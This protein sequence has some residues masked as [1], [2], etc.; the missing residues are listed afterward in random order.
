MQE[1]ALT[2]EKNLLF[3]S[4]KITL[5]W[6]WRSS[7]GEFTAPAD[8]V[9]RHLF[10]TFRMIWNNAMPEEARVGEVRLY[11]FQPFY[12]RAYMRDAIV[13]IGR[14]LSTRDDLLPEWKWQ[15]QQM[16]NWFAKYEEVNE[17]RLKK[18]QQRL[19]HG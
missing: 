16:A 13:M 9:S 19:S 15:L 3:G 12:S 5:G 2:E 6:R 18:P 4:R 17:A 10:H 1:L 7:N 11:T 14:E 8:M